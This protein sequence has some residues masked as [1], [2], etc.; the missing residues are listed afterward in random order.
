MSVTESND[1]N[2]GKWRYRFTCDEC[3][4]SRPTF[5]EAYAQI[6]EKTH[7]CEDK[8]VIIHEQTPN[9]NAGT[10]VPHRNWTRG[11]DTPWRARMSTIDKTLS[12]GV[13]LRGIHFSIS[14]GE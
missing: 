3:G 6:I 4:Y 9:Q 14:Y 10:P 12:F 8:E 7:K 11:R 13:W 2:N 1:W 5:T